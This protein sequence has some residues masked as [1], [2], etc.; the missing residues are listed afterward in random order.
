MT[1]NLTFFKV[2]SLALL[3]TV[4]FAVPS[5]SAINFDIGGTITLAKDMIKAETAA[6]EIAEQV[7]QA[8]DTAVAIGSDFSLSDPLKP[9]NVNSTIPPE[10]QMSVIPE[11]VMKLLKVEDETSEPDS[12]V[13]QEEIK[14]IA[15]V[16]TKT[17]ELR[18]LTRNQQ[19]VLLLKVASSG[20]A[21]A[22]A[23]FIKSEKATEDNQKMAEEIAKATDH[24]GLWNNMAKLQLAMMHKQGEVMHLR[25]R[26]LETISAQALIGAEA[27][28]DVSKIDVA[29]DATSSDN[30]A[31]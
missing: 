21:T 30:Q 27:L 13:V 6:K 20:Y 29:S 16:K 1:H 5:W 22:N 3:G 12:V 26:M 24:I 10:Q 19:N 11:N 18:K 7:K 23:S 8:A 4:C 15:F 31:Q 14:K 9:A 28:K 2:F 25:T 17:P